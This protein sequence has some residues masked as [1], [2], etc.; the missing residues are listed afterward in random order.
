MKHVLHDPAHAFSGFAVTE[1]AARG[2]EGGCVDAGFLVGGDQPAF[3]LA[4]PG[5]D[6]QSDPKRY[7]ENK[8]QKIFQFGTLLV[9][10]SGQFMAIPTIWLALGMMVTI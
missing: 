10:G 5:I 9:T 7:P 2:H 1:I 4:L 8:T 3:R 6:R